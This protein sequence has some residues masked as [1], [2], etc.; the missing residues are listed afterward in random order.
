MEPKRYIVWSTRKVDLDDP[1]QRKWYIRQVLTHGRAEDIAELDWE[2]V[3][4]VLKEIILPPPVR[5]LWEG[6]FGA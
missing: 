3:R 2:E 5:R 4:S 6:Y 1:W